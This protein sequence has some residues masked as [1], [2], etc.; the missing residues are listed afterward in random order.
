VMLTKAQTA[1][2]LRQSMKRCEERL[3]E[4]FRQ[5]GLERYRNFLKQK[6]EKEE[7]VNSD[8]LL[9]N[10]SASGSELLT[11]HELIEAD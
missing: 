5:E 11:E 1:E 4:D 3:N 9:V 8:N 6:D 7:K 10:S 2:L